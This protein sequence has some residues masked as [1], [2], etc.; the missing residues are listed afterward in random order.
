MSK[1]VS[2]TVTDNSLRKWEKKLRNAR[3]EEQVKKAE[4]MLKA[5]RPKEKVDKVPKST[6]TDDQLIQEAI[7]GTKKDYKFYEE[8]R[9][10]EKKQSL[11]RDRKRAE[12]LSRKRKREEEKVANLEEEKEKYEKYKEEQKEHNKR[13]LSH[14]GHAEKFAEQEGMKGKLVDQHKN[15]KKK[16]EKEY[17]KFINKTCENIELSIQ[18]VKDSNEI[19]YEEALTLVYSKTVKEEEAT[20]NQED[21]TQL[22]LTDKVEE[23][24]QEDPVQEEPVAEELTE[25]EWQKIV[26]EHPELKM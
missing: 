2:K 8:K 12:I 7:E 18:F 19:S 22:S 15:N 3:S 9:V 14:G 20:S 26:E 11:E 1:T 23:P 10:H 17:K 16:I 4:S 21:S 6:F 24:I 13:V 25:E 5:L